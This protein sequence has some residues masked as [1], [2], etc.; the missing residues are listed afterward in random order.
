[1]DVAVTTDYRRVLSEILIR[2]LENP[3]LGAI[4]P[5]YTGYSPL[6]VVQGTDLDPIYDNP[7]DEIFSDGFED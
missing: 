3:Y 7:S 5:G 4:F 6:G 1:M 2:R